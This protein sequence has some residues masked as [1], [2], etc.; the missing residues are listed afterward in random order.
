MSDSESELSENETNDINSK[1]YGDLIPEELREIAKD[2]AL[3]LLPDKSKR[4]YTVAYNG[5]K[6]WRSEK[7]SNSFDEIV[8]LAYFSHLSLKYAPPSLWATFSMLKSTISAYNDIDIGKYKKLIAFLKKKMKGYRSKKSEVF[9]T[10]QVN[11]FLNEA[12]D[13]EYLL[14]KV[15]KNYSIIHKFY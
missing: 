14:E 5:F 9:T 4:L 6:K 1:E 12:S 7:K 13:N 2:V 10:D 3:N 11:K 8:L 15:N